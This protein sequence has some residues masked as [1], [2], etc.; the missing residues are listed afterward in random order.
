MLDVRFEEIRGGQPGSQYP[1]LLLSLVVVA[2][3][4][5]FLSK[6]RLEGAQGCKTSKEHAQYEA[7]HLRLTSNRKSHQARGSL[8]ISR[9]LSLAGSVFLSFITASAAALSGGVRLPWENGGASHIRYSR[10][11]IT[12]A[13]MCQVEQATSENIHRYC[14]QKL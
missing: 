13:I 8:K 11:E 2:I 3:T 12:A 4:W 7:G 1:L 9:V 10:N 5:V 6:G 14:V